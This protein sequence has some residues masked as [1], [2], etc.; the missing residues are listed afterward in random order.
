MK[1][2]NIVPY[3]MLLAMCAF[4]WAIICKDEYLPQAMINQFLPFLAGK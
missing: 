3:L 4:V 1:D 2:F